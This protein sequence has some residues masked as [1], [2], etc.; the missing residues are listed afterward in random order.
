[1]YR[2]PTKTKAS[3]ISEHSQIPI[4][5]VIS[6]LVVVSLHAGWMAKFDYTLNSIKE[7]LMLARE[8]RW[9][10]SLQQDFSRR[11]ESW[12]DLLQAKNPELEV[13]E[14]SF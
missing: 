9:T 7:E 6:L 14:T 8:D 1:M 4:K 10:K 3:V 5:L 13:P 2:E 11:I 12:I